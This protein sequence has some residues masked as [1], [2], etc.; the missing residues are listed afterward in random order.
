MP[1]S[2]I[3]YQLKIKVTKIVLGSTSTLREY[4]I[5]FKRSSIFEPLDCIENFTFN[6]RMRDVSSSDLKMHL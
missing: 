4:H 5:I 1:S 6:K 2:I 3:S